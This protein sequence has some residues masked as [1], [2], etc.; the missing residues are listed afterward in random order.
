ATL[1]SVAAWTLP[2]TKRYGNPCV[3]T[4]IAGSDE[5]GPPVGMRILAG[6]PARGQGCALRGGHRVD[7]RRT[8]AQARRVQRGHPACRRGIVDAPQ[9]HDHAARTGK[10]ERAAQPEGAFV[11]AAV[12]EAAV[13]G[14]EHHPTGAI[15]RKLQD[16]LF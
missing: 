15:E 16:V 1:P 7:G 2:R 11:G 8:V 9:A 12:A 13:A 3:S 10:A 5:T 6:G 14:R 4:P